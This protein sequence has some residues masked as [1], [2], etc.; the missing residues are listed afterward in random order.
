MSRPP[1]RATCRSRS[2]GSTPSTG[3]Q[4]VA[5]LGQAITRPERREPDRVLEP[6]DHPRSRA[7][8]APHPGPAPTPTANLLSADGLLSDLDGLRYVLADSDIKLDA[9]PV[10]HA[11]NGVM[12][13][14][15]SDRPWHLADTTQQVYYG[16]LVPRLVHLHVLQAGPGGD[17]QGL[18]RTPGVQRLGPCR[19]GRA[20]SSATSTTTPSTRRSTSGRSTAA[21][22]SLFRTGARG[23]SRFPVAQTPVRVEL[24]IATD[25]LIPPTDNEPRTLGV[26]VGL[27]FVPASDVSRPEVV[28]GAHARG[29]RAAARRLG[30][31]AVGARG[32]SVRVL[33]DPAA[34]AAGRDRAVRRGR[35]RRRRPPV[36]GLA[37][38]LELAPALDRRSATRSSTPRRSGCSGRRRR[39]R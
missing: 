24:T 36:G 16:Q 3:G 19:Q 23:R 9:T 11:A 32:G 20:S 12:T 28:G 14:Y 37:G 39:D 18:A 4:P 27:A 2:T 29:A 13:L 10:A 35:L 33:H 15:R 6:V 34:H 31:A 1:S 22:T 5:Y 38:G 25:T 7:S 21:S 30:R 17:A 26:Q 8:T